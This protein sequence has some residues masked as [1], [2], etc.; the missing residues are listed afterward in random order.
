MRIKCLAQEHN[1]M[2]PARAQTRSAR[3]GVANFIPLR[4]PLSRIPPSINIR[5]VLPHGHK[6]LVC[7][8]INLLLDVLLCSIAENFYLLFVF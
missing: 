6:T 3:S 2:F 4:I 1:T 8:I 7:W 5:E